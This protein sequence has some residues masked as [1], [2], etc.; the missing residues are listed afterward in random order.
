MMSDVGGCVG[1]GQ[2]KEQGT[3]VQNSLYSRLR[4]LEDSEEGKE[5]PGETGSLNR[6]LCWKNEIA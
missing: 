6:W 1:T 4:S 5:E 2:E 3:V